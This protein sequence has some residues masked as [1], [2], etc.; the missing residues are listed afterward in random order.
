MAVVGRISTEW[1]ERVLVKVGS[2]VDRK[3]GHWMRSE[4]SVLWWSVQTGLLEEQLAKRS[5]QRGDASLDSP[6]STSAEPSWGD[7][8][9]L[10]LTAQPDDVETPPQADLDIGTGDVTARMQRNLTQI[11][12]LELQLYRLRER[13]LTLRQKMVRRRLLLIGNTM[14]ESSR[15]LTLPIGLHA[16]YVVPRRTARSLSLRQRRPPSCQWMVCLSW[17]PHPTA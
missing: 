16:P 9:P 5:S 4:P 8:T 6:A 7:P 1:I 13:A 11:E 17:P 14:C 15:L 3:R 10:E 12:C 2:H